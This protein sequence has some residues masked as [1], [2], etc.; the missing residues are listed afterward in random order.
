MQRSPLRRRSIQDAP[1]VNGNPATG[2]QGSIPPAAAFEFQ[3][4]ETDR[5]DRRR[6][7][8]RR[9]MTTCSK[10]CKAARRQF[11]NYCT[12]SRRRQFAAL[13]GS[14]PPIDAYTLGMP[15]RIRVAATNTGASSF[16][17]GAGRHPIKRVNGAD[18]AAGDLPA[19]GMITVAVGRHQFSDDQ[20]SRH[21]RR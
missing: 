13:L 12:D 20:L 7:I 18:T 9:P 11:I 3:Q 14:S 1:Y 4:R 19:G 15:F 5:A 10:S 21:R 8:C 6:R 17:A 16:D 2:Q